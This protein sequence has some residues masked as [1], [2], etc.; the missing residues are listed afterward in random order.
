MPVVFPA[1]T[2]RRSRKRKRKQSHPTVCLAVKGMAP[3]TMFGAHVSLRVAPTLGGLLLRFRGQPLEI[4]G[5]T[6]PD[7][8]RSVENEAYGP[9]GVQRGHH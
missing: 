1:E 7:H 8:K 5:M 4:A 6:M 2:K 3:G 9:T